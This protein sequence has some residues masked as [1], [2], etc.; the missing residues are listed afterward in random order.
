MQMNSVHRDQRPKFRRQ[1]RSARDRRHRL[2]DGRGQYPEGISGRAA[3][4][5]QSFANSY[6][7][8]CVLSHAFSTASAAEIVRSAILRD[9]ARKACSSGA[10]NPCGPS[11]QYDRTVLSRPSNASKSSF[12]CDVLPS[13]RSAIPSSTSARAS[14]NFCCAVATGAGSSK[15]ETRTRYLHKATRI[16]KSIRN[17]GCQR[18]IRPRKTRSRFREGPVSNSTAS[19][20]ALTSSKLLLIISRNEKARSAATVRS[21]ESGSRANWANNRKEEIKVLCISRATGALQS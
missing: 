11:E 18:L 9:R 21:F 16:M 4:V 5:V 2:A 19:A 20:S 1:G 13:D 15:P 14:S 8:S 3:L 12:P 10:S 6:L 17:C 7:F